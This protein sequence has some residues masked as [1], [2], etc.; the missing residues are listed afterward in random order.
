MD[1]TDRGSET[2]DPA[3]GGE[4]RSEGGSRDQQARG[5]EAT[6]NPVPQGGGATGGRADPIAGDAGDEDG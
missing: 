5:G 3:S 1:S 4:G 2:T 6:G